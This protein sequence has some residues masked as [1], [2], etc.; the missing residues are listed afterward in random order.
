MSKFNDLTG[1]QF[2]K[3]TVLYQS[4]TISSPNGTRRTMWHCKCECGNEK[5]VRADTLVS[6]RTKSCGKCKNDLTGKR[7]GKLTVLNKVGADM[8]GHIIWRCMCDCGNETNVLG[9]NLIQQYTQSCGCV[10][11]EVCSERGENLIGQKFGK[12]TVVS[13][14]GTMPRKYLCSCECG[15]QAI[16]Q[17]YN[18]KNGHTN[19]CGCIS[20]L[21]QETINIYLTN[22]NINFKP[23]YCVPI[24]GFKGL[25]RYD[26]AVF[27][28][29]YKIKFLIEYHGRQ[30]YQVA[31]SWND[32]SDDLLDRQNK[33]L[34]KR[35][36]AKE[37]NIPIYE[38]PHWEF[39]NITTILDNIIK[40]EFSNIEEIN[41][42]GLIL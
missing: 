7:F 42:Q 38:I 28:N 6:G 36:W 5:D 35:Q 12:L 34:M 22:H 32:T 25:A 30:H 31:N 9:T 26:F 17:P 3:L 29:N 14:V 41:E 40:K 4:D 19:S 27:D 16:V 11:S 23:E 13:L 37:N 8:S 1:L 39:K 20:S 10:H 15:G 18:L 24:K 33:D 21:G 2:G